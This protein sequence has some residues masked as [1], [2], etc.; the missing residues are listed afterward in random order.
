MLASLLPG[1]RHLRTP[2]A[3]GALCAFQLWVLFGE[4]LPSRNEAHGLVKRLY[5][6]G[7]I[8][9]RPMV[10]AII[11]FML[12]LLGDIMK[13]SQRWTMKINALFFGSF[14]SITPESMVSLQNFALKAFKV[15]GV[16]DPNRNRVRML[17]DNIQFEF[18][19]IRV[20]LIAFNV[21]AYMESDRLE[22]E[23]EFRTNIATYAIPLWFV[24]AY[25]W[26]S[27]FLFGTLATVALYR[28]GISALHASNG[29]LVQSLISELVTSQYFATELKEDEESE[30]GSGAAMAEPLYR[31]FTLRRDS[32][33]VAPE[34]ETPIT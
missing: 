6:L 24:L 30:P 32:A 5:E 25:S 20:R 27:W 13:L 7:E 22:S 9:G 21:D 26:S 16:T 33:V 1:F 11:A 10:T 15:R 2:F 4:S 17:I 19:E 34:S 14:A 3:V 31:P 12:Y 23:A 28:S 8:A 29:I 18:P